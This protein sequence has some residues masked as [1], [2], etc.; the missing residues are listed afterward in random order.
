MADR[1]ERYE[2]AMVLAGAGDAIGYK[3][4]S[5]EF[6][7][8]G[9]QIHQQ[10]A[11]LGGVDRIEVDPRRWM[12]S[13]DTVMH[14]A[15][16][17]A[18]V[19]DWAGRK[20]LYHSLARHYKACMRDMAGRAPGG[21]TTASCHL[22]KPGVPNGYSIPFNSRGGGCGAAMRAAPIGL[23]YPEPGQIRDLVAVAVESGRMTH[24]HPTGY[25]G[26]L[27]TAL[28]V[29]YGIQRKPL[30]E[31]GAGLVQTLDLAWEY[32][33]EC[34]RDVGE[35]RSHWS[36]FKEN[37]TGY[38]QTRGILDGQTEPAF[39]DKYGVAERDAFYKS[40]SYGG[41]GGASGHDAPMIAYDALLGSGESWSEL[42]HRAVLHGGDSDSTGIIAAASWGAMHGFRGVPRA[43]YEKLEYADRLRRLAAEIHKRAVIKEA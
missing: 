37:W 25:L 8:S 18:L 13:D 33:E 23:F 9:Q 40:L 24:N 10:L 19:S 3:N 26:S 17:E 7:H 30:A 21:T 4:G 36:Y 27:A 2:A 35:N 15:T 14:I 11:S 1:Q 29:S 20:E 43:N 12:V 16:A 6:C 42:V 41:W 39:P 34:G 38:L 32:V 22:L 28:F 5:W 31:W